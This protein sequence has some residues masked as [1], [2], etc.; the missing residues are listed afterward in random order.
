MGMLNGQLLLRIGDE[1]AGHSHL[2]KILN[3]L[4]ENKAKAAMGILT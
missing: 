3:A 2:I 1:F 4:C